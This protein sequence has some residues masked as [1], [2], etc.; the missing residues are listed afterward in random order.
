MQSLAAKLADDPKS[1]E[2]PRRITEG[3]K[4]LQALVDEYRESPRY[5]WISIKYERCRW[6][7]LQ[8]TLAAYLAVPARQAVREWSLESIR[9]GLDRLEKIQLQV[10]N[11]AARS[12]KSNGNTGPTS[13]EWI[14]LSNDIRLLQADLMLV[15]S[16]FYPV[17]STERIAAATEILTAIEKAQRQI[18]PNWT[19]R[20]N[21]ELARCRALLLVD[22]PEEALSELL[23]LKKNLE[24]PSDAKQRPD[25]RWSERIATLA[26]EANRHLNRIDESNRWIE[27]A[28]GW[29]KSPEL[30]MEHFANQVAN[31]QTKTSN[32]SPL[33]QAL[34]IKAEIGKRF[35][36][37]WQ[38]RADAILVSN[39]L[40]IAKSGSN[41]TDNST[42]KLKIELLMSEGKQLLSAKRPQE[43]I[44]KLR[45]AEM[46]AA[47]A[48]DESRALDIAIGI[49]AIYSNTQQQEL[50]Q[51]EFHRA[52]MQYP[53][54]AKAPDAALMSVWQPIIDG[55]VVDET[56]TAERL[57]TILQRLT[58]IV[59]TWP[60][61][62]Q[63]TQACV[64][65]DRVYLRTDRLIDLAGLWTK[66]LE[67]LTNPDADPGESARSSILELALSRYALINMLT[68]DD[69]LERSQATKENLLLQQSLRSLQDQLLTQSSAAHRATMDSFCNA[70][71]DAGRWPP[72]EL[73]PIATAPAKDQLPYALKVMAGQLKSDEII[74]EMAVAW[75]RS[76]LI[77][78]QAI[79]RGER[80]MPLDPASLNELSQSV[81]SLPQLP[82]DHETELAKLLSPG[83][84]N[85][86]N[87]SRTLYLVGLQ[88]WT[89]DEAKGVAGMIEAQRNDP[90]RA[91]WPYRSAR[92]LQTIPAQ[93]ELAVK[94]FRLLANGFPAGSDAWL[95]ARARTAQTMRLMGQQANA[96]KIS[97][98]I[99]ATYPNLSP[100]WGDRLGK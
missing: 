34:Q 84:L 26:A 24:E 90:R 29:T 23:K 37:Y 15:R 22:R 85:H 98:L 83:H 67:Q 19:G 45:Q 69:W 74:A 92:V 55:E 17:K 97:E 4:E 72:S 30:A 28:G 9:I 50:A 80:G 54:L 70:I 52:A 51:S 1:V 49:A 71:R 63:A 7:V 3:L 79:R 81:A 18:S 35:S 77:F 43:A 60:S 61:S 68:Q 20:P 8:R 36:H 39:S 93:R 78:Q 41:A 100:E 76:E 86:L 48:Q 99:L 40:A 13:S 10:K 59:D 88:C 33:A 47:N 82:K 53:K 46:S 38:Q 95:E 58:D 66:R 64:R 27:R 62:A 91:W 6:Y 12:P 96:N 16:S 21:V 75:T 89:G 87:N 44:E 5:H 31:A 11:D 73:W 42:A 25:L 2:E 32:A 57:A 56:K 14:S 65:L 94:Q